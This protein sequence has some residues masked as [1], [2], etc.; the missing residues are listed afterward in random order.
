MFGVGRSAFAG[1]ASKDFGL[2]GLFDQEYDQEQEQDSRYTSEPTGLEP[3]TS[4]VT[5]QRSNQLS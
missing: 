1:R 2:T 5:G 4:A 3:A